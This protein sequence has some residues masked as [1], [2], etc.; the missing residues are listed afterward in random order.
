MA[1][2]K[3]PQP[4]GAQANWLMTFSDMV[5]LLLCFFVL[6]NM[7]STL[8]VEKFKQFI[9]NFQ[10]NPSIF[11]EM[12]NRHELGDTGVEAAPTIPDF[13]ISDPSDWWGMLGDELLDLIAAGGFGDNTGDGPGG[14]P[15]G[16]VINLIID[17]ARII[18]RVQGEILFDTTSDRLRPESLE[19]LDFI[20]ETLILPPLNQGQISDI[21]IEGHADIRQIPS[22]YHPRFRNNKD[23]SAARAIAAWEY[24]VDNFDIPDDKVGAVGY[25]E[26]RPIDGD[27][28]NSGNWEQDY[29]QW[30]R[31]R[32]VEFVMYRDVSFDEEMNM[33]ERA[34]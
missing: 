28:G 10:G 15:S 31:N 24:V 34:A 7:M 16:P 5:T 21:H 23:L 4:Q 25:G 22:G 30:Q 27:V 20:A 33:Y 32:R 8:D 3:K 11:D 26:L 9:K 1:R 6:L 13:W 2:Q 14:Q 17:D 12:N 29:A 18:L 19:V